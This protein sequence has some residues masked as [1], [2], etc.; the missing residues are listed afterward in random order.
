MERNLRELRVLS[1]GELEMTPLF[2]PTRNRPTALSNMLRYLVRFYP[3][4]HVIIADGSSENYKSLNRQTVDALKHDLAIDYR[5]YPADL[6]IF[7]RMLDVLRSESFEFVINGSDD[8]F[9]MIDTLREGEAFL[10]DHQDYSTAIGMLV[11]LWL[12][13]P[14]ELRTQMFPI[15]PIVANSA[16]SRVRQY[17][18]DHYLFATAY[19]VARREALIERYERSGKFF[20]VSFIDY[21]LGIYDC[22]HG[23]IK[24]L[25]K[26]GFIC[27]RNYGH[28]YLRT[29]A[30]LQYLRRSSEVLQQADQFRKDLMQYACLDEETAKKESAH[31]IKE[32]IRV[33][34]RRFPH[35]MRAFNRRP[36]DPI[37]Q[38]QFDIFDAMFE[39]GT[40][41]RA[42]YEERLTFIIQAMKANAESDDNKGERKKT[43]TLE[44]QMEMLAGGP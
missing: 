15:R 24:A 4:T 18:A 12:D 21:T 32:R 2:I 23:K 40:P 13:S 5:P 19:G 6:P 25:P 37:V 27:T 7:D 10:R 42:E 36:T 11:N 8:D 30:G 14:V 41:A 38:E 3:S 33:L 34:V 43:E 39:Q 31:L 16:L 29:E 35:K 20:L 9:P 1:V 44:S 26:V 22:L 28:A 17:A